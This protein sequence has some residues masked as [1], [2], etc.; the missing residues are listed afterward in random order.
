MTGNLTYVGE[1]QV[2]SD[3]ADRL[4]IATTPTPLV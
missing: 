3:A 2:A 4:R 1:A